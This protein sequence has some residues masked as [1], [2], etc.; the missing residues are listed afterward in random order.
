[1][2]AIGYHWQESRPVVVD[3]WRSLVGAGG[4]D[5]AVGRTDWS[6]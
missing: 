5:G 2:L 4:R 1:M 6:H 3:S